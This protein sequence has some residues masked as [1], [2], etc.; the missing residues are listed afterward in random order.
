M[1]F[2]STLTVNSVVAMAGGNATTTKAPTSSIKT[3]TR[4]TTEA[5]TATEATT[6]AENTTEAISAYL[7][8]K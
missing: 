2:N 7:L 8:N 1:F 5:T 6:E 3:T 4:T